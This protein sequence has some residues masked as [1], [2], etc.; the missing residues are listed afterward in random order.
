MALLIDEV[1][2]VLGLADL[3]R[4]S[5]L[6]ARIEA[7]SKTKDKRDEDSNNHISKEDCWDFVRMKTRRFRCGIHKCIQK[8]HH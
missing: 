2:D 7:A 6:H 8:E 5:V 3:G 4:V 1:N